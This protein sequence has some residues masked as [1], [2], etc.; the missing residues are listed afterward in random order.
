MRAMRRGIGIRWWLTVAFAV[1]AV[2]TA[3]AASQLFARASEGAF[4]E[5]A[6]DLAA[7]NAVSAAIEL[8]RADRS[9]RLPGA[10]SELAREERLALFVFDKEGRLV[11]PPR[12]RNVTVESIRVRKEAVATALAGRR[13]V[14]TNDSVR[15]TTV[16]LPFRGGALLAYAYHPDLAAG[17]G[18]LRDEIVTAALWA[19]VLGGTVGVLVA[20]LISVRLRRIA[21]AAAAMEAGDLQTPLRPG[22]GDELGSLGATVER[23]RQRLRESF[24]NLASERDRL[25]RIVERLREGVLSVNA[26]L[27]VE[28]A[29]G[30]ARTLL[31]A[32]RLRAGDP[33]PDPWPPFEL[34]SF[35]AG[36]FGADARAAEATVTDAHER[37]LA[38]AGIPPQGGSETAILVLVDVSERERRERAEREFVANAAHELRTPLTTIVGAVE[39]LQGGAKGDAAARER[40]LGHIEREAGRLARLTRALLV[41]A[42]AETGQELPPRTSVPVRALLEQVGARLAPAPG[43]AVDVECDGDVTLFTERDLVEQALWNLASNAARHTERGRIVL[44]A[45]ATGNGSVELEVTDTGSGIATAE[46]ERVFERFYRGNGRSQD[47]FGLGLSIVRQAVQALGGTIDVHSAPGSGTRVRVRLPAGVD[48]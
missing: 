13:F 2:V 45:R 40:F 21:R 38:I 33:L 22:F 6:Q 46:Q 3:V 9:G 23:M 1:I 18:I 8:G 43:V 42:R 19:V 20:S 7:G 39:A 4:R 25:E 15:A 32:P 31:D 34:E 24:R 14:E 48:L 5:R 12:S 37:T 30:A 11:S 35:A 26:D 41:L 27:T 16:A 36:L 47:G 17:L 44:A 29:N 28:L 10:V